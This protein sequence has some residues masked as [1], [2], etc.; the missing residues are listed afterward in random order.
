[1]GRWLLGLLLVLNIS[2]ALWGW[3]RDRALDPPLP[4]PAQAP[5]QILLGTEWLGR[6]SAVTEQPETRP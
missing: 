3:T 2:L 5:G 4:P 1:M 6:A